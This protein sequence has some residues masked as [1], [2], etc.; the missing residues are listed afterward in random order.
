MAYF[1]GEVQKEEAKIKALADLQDLR[2]RKDDAHLVQYQQ[3][4]AINLEVLRAD[5]DGDIETVHKYISYVGMPALSHSVPLWEEHLAELRVQVL[6]L[7]QW[8]G[9]LQEACQVGQ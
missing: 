2:R 7:E 5:E 1:E 9:E 6:K 8:I 4:L 3:Q